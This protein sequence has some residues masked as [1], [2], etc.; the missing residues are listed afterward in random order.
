MEAT[1]NMPID[2]L[3]EKGSD[4]VLDQEF[5]GEI[6]RTQESDKYDSKS[7]K[8]IKRKF[9]L[10]LLPIF[11]LVYLAMSIDRAS[12]G[13]ANIEGLGEDLQLEGYDLNLALTAF[14]ICYGAIEIP[15]NMVIKKFPPRYWLSLST[16]LFGLVS[17]CTAFVKNYG[18]LVATRI[19]LGFFEGGMQPGITF[20]LSMFY[21]RSELQVRVGFFIASAAL[22]GA[23]GGLLAM[24]LS[25]IPTHGPVKKWGWIFLLE[26]IMT[27]IIGICA[28]FILPDSPKS[29][30]FLAYDQREAAH[31][32]VEVELRHSKDEKINRTQLVLGFKSLHSWLCGLAFY[33]TGLVVQ[34]TSLF[35]PTLLKGM[36]YTSSRAQLMSVPPF[37]AGCFFVVVSSYASDYFGVRGP[38]NAFYFLLCVI[39][40]VLL[41]TEDRLGVRYFAT[42]LIC[43]GGF[44]LGPGV[45]TWS[46]NNAAS[47]TTRAVATAIV[48]IVG[49]L[50]S[51]TAMWIYL[52]KYAPSYDEGHK[53]LIGTCSG[54]VV[55]CL[56]MST[57]LFYENKARDEGK[58]NGLTAKFATDEE[59]KS[60]LAHRHPSFRYLI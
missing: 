30:K 17:M 12:I 47:H 7:E 41:Y 55:L 57:Y 43:M 59:A 56:G 45:L 31:N 3:K 5:L 15:S 11:S 22:A 40:Y 33:L 14:F 32:R 39:G 16:V 50:G 1:Y 34:S 29:A 25:A 51:I 10:Y 42:F 46:S 28:F 27:M 49:T 48:A 21:K 35:L 44:S 58:R 60:M 13:N 8:E 4:F 53:I 18:G 23:F 36:G 19:F 54:G 24:G 52:P 20:A 2:E 6:E 37:A 38:F 26:G 9:D